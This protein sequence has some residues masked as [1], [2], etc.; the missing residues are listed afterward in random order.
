MTFLSCSIQLPIWKL[1]FG[2]QEVF[3]WGVQKHLKLFAMQSARKSPITLDEVISLT[4]L[5]L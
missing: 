5:H 1:H 2:E 3:Y 4:E